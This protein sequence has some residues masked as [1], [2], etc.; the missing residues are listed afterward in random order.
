MLLRLSLLHHSYT[1][2]VLAMDCYAF[3]QPAEVD[4]LAASVDKQTAL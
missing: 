2:E 1:Y 4:A 3:G